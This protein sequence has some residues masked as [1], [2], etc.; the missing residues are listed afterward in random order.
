L[1]KQFGE[2]Q[3]PEDLINRIDHAEGWIKGYAAAGGAKSAGGNQQAQGGGA[4]I[5][6]TTQPDGVYEKD[7]KHFRAQGGKVYAQ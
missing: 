7:G 4:P 3:S 5:G 2:A 6:T 1:K